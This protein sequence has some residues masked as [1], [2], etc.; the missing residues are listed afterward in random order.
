M[1]ILTYS[2]KETLQ[3]GK[4][5]ARCVDAPCVIALHGD[6]GSGKT[7]LTKG[8]VAGLF[9]RTK[10]TVKSPSFA[11]VNQYQG[12]YPVYHIDCYRLDGAADCAEIGIDEFLYGHGIA[13]IEWPEKIASLLPA[14]TMHIH[15]TAPEETT[16]SF[17]LCAPAGRLASL[18]R[19]VRACKK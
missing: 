10:I 7:T 1:R 6:L 8:I 14:E 5:I 3:L 15:I 11:L 17:S 2:E 13:I 12:S 18:R 9:P 4:K 19:C 16:R